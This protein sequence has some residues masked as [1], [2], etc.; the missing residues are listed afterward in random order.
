MTVG[1]QT[2]RDHAM[3]LLDVLQVHLGQLRRSRTVGTEAIIAECEEIIAEV[4]KLVSP[5][6]P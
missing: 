3:H 5:S 2:W 6:T 1:P 4:R